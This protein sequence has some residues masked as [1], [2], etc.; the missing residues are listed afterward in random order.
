VQQLK[1]DS[2]LAWVLILLVGISLFLSYEVWI[3]VPGESTAYRKS[4]ERAS[5]DL[6]SVI[7]P[8]KMIVHM[9]NSM[10]TVLNPS[11]TF[12][13]DIWKLSKTLLKNRWSIENPEPVN[14]DLESIQQK[15][16]VEIVFPTPL[17]T[18]L[19]KQIFHDDSGSAASLEDILLDSFLIFEDR[20][21][22]V[23]LRDIDGK[24]YKIGSGQE[25]DEL[26]SI[27][28]KIKQS[29]PLLYAKLP[30]ANIR[31]KISRGIFISLQDYELPVYDIKKERKS[32]DQTAT[33]F[34]PD[35]SITRKI[36]EKDGAVIY[37]DG[38]RGLR[39]YQDGAVE[40]SFPGEKRQEKTTLRDALNIAVDFINTHGGWPRDT[41]LHS[42]DVM[43]ESQNISYV[44]RFRYRVNGIP[45][46]YNDEDYLV[47][48]VEGNQVK[49]FYRRDVSE[50]KPV[51][52]KSLM[53]PIQALDAAVA[54][55]NIREVEDILPAYQYID[56]VIKPVWVLKTRADQVIIPEP[57]E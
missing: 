19:L 40:Y 14:I 16:S 46:I 22:Q 51:S 52:S 55:K 26:D 47:V 28:D 44:F 6:A 17:N 7:S 5:V 4:N 36:K 30:S 34:F 1:K 33:E 23:Y 42:Y 2:V 41:Y 21:L 50:G 39:I 43:D 27:I 56:D 9:G 54:I 45:L 49:R 24:F 31:L 25:M 32:L 35:L 53:H 48:S 10:H 3:R 38:Q 13:S 18:S 20:E 15:K 29:K 37:T 11:S 8:E 12:Y 57:L